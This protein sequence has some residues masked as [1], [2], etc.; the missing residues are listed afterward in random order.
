[1]ITCVVQYEI[2]PDLL[3]EF[4]HYAKLWVPLVKKHGG[5]HNGY[6]M[7]HESANDMAL[8]LFSFKSLADYERYR[9]DILNDP[10]CVAAFDFAKKTKCIRRYDRTFLKPF[11]APMP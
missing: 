4:E 5:Y 10:D 11:M 7:P 6:F 3:D 8:A 9:K 1:M 2:E